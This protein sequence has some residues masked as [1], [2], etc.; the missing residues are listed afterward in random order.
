MVEAFHE[1]L[2]VRQVPGEPRMRWFLSDYFEL[3]VWFGDDELPCA[4][5]LCYDRSYQEHAI[6]WE[7]NKPNLRHQAVDDGESSLHY[8]RSPIVAGAGAP[9]PASIVDR[10]DATVGEIPDELRALVLRELRAALV[11]VE[12]PD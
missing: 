11:A 9:F 5:R 10:F 7:R 3:F 2:H 8:A 4:F 1:Y 12:W 6:T